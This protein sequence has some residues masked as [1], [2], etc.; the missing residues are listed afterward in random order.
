MWK[1]VTSYESGLGWILAVE[2]TLLPISLNKEDT[3]RKSYMII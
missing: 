2:N 3:K 1:K